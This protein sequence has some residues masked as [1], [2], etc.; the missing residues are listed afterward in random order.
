MYIAFK[1]GSARQCVFIFNPNGLFLHDFFLTESNH[2]SGHI[3]NMKP[4][5]YTSGKNKTVIFLITLTNSAPKKED[6]DSELNTIN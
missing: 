1:V 5:L 3:I 4:C 6:D 2:S